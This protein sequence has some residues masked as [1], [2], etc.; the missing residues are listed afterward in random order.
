MDESNKRIFVK[1]YEGEE[2]RDASS[3][4]RGF[5]FQD[6]L[7]V[8]E[9]LNDDTIYIC[10]EYI[11]DILVV[12]DSEVR[13]IQAKYYPNSKPKMPE[14]I[15]DL[16]YQYLRFK[17]YD[18]I[19][20]IEPMLCVHSP[21]SSI[22]PLFNELQGFIAVNKAQEPPTVE[23]FHQ[24][25]IE[26]VYALK[27]KKD[28]QNKLFERFA[29]NESMKDFLEI[30][31]I[32]TNYK[33]L[34]EY[35][36][37]IAKRI[38]QLPFAKQAAMDKS[39]KETVLLGL[40]VQYIQEAYIEEKNTFEERKCERKAFL[41]YLEENICMETEQQIAA[42]LYGIVIETWE[43]I[44]NNN[45]L[46]QENIDVLQCVCD[47]TARWLFTLGTTPEGQ[48]Q[49]LNTVSRG[50][51]KIFN[52]F[53]E[54]SVSDRLQCVYVHRDCVIIFLRYLWKIIFDLIHGYEIEKMDENQKNLL[55]PEVYFDKNEKRYLKSVFREDNAES[56]IILSGLGNGNPWECLKNILDRAKRIRPKKWYLD[57]CLCNFNHKTLHGRYD[58][59][60]DVG[61]LKNE[62]RNS[63]AILSEETFRIECMNCIHVDMEDWNFPE[64]CNNTIFTNNCVEEEE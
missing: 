58:Y 35:R 4:I 8:D 53:T 15:R 56:S 13:Y 6:L 26:N 46:S 45:K 57:N 60:L 16:Y 36:I 47:N 44:E 59:N 37:T 30:L 63:V 51:N 55:C 21:N 28:I 43:V 5:L 23:D 12:S 61:K 62:K 3:S 31:K 32:D 64:N 11:E 1:M 9:L 40:A 48:L 20:V 38:C 39:V 29:W 17:L 41:Q 10:L 7:A 52:G 34:E 27:K 22:K 18:Y 49:L 14:I 24:W 25:M 33:N 42:Y 2:V 50:E 19:G 54:R